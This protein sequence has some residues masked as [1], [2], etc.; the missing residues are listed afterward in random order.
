M[1]DYS[2]YDLTAFVADSR[3]AAW[4]KYGEQD[5]FWTGFLAQYP[6]QQSVVEQAVAIILAA[7][8]LPMH[9]PSGAQRSQMWDNIEAMTGQAL[10]DDGASQLPLSSQSAMFP[11]VA[12][13][14]PVSS[15]PAM[16]PLV[17]EDSLLSQANASTQI[18]SLRKASS[19]RIW[20]ASAAAALVAG[21]IA[22]PLLW[23]R[24]HKPDNYAAL[25]RRAGIGETQRIEA[26]N[27]TKAP[28]WISLPDG[29]SAVLA[30]G[31]RLSYAD[32]FNHL[33]QREVYLSGAA[34]FEV[35]KKASHPFVV[36]ANTLAVKVLGTSFSVQAPND[37][38][39]VQVNV[40]SGKV[41]L[42]AGKTGRGEDG[43]SL[44]VNAG[45][46]AAMKKAALYLLHET[47]DSGSIAP[48]ADAQ[49]LNV[50][51]NIPLTFEDASLQEVFDALE[52][53]YGIKISYDREKLSHCRLT[54][55]LSDEPLPEKIRLICKAI[56]APYEI[57]GN[58]VVIL[59]KK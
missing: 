52:K 23:P 20:W 47:E 54:A 5:A 24:A 43:T 27:D 2:K 7:A 19:R 14:E 33:D 3:F 44:I 6:H 32:N 56:Q 29:S 18:I 35:D 40:R 4:V 1:E 45:Q 30:P 31:G 57:N 34:F 17:A 11:Q 8:H 12:S 37:A 13:S 49:V 59:D 15:Q 28:L 51:Q 48:V 42:Y 50:V 53:G 55:F 21:A 58:E 36:Y 25:L 22:I 46:K 10:N 38:P 41:M 39:E 26:M 16:F 9:Y